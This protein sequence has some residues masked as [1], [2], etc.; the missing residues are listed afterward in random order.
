MNICTLWKNGICIKSH[1]IKTKLP[2]NWKASMI[3]PSTKLL[4]RQSIFWGNLKCVRSV[5]HRGSCPFIA[6]IL[7]YWGSPKP[8][9][10]AVW[11]R[12]LHFTRYK[13]TKKFIQ[14]KINDFIFIWVKVHSPPNVVSKWEASPF[15]KLQNTCK[16]YVACLDNWGE[17]KFHPEQMK[18]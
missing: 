16:L 12:F 6:L 18:I 13:T 4:C 8:L 2:W 11:L 14:K 17:T 10:S 15:R 3:Y 7:L 9:V 5:F 1:I